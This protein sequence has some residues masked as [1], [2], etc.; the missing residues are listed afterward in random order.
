MKILIV[1]NEIYL[2]QS[3]SAKLTEIGY[4]CESVTTINEALKGGKYDAILLSTNISGQNFYPIIKKYKGAII[5]LLISYISQDTVLKPIKEGASDY[6]QKPFMIEELIR[7]L[8]HLRFFH[9]LKKQNQTYKNYIQYLFKDLKADYND[10]KIK[11]PLAIKT[12]KRE[13]ADYFVYQY[14]IKTNQ[15]F[16]FLSLACK[17]SLEKIIEKDEKDFLYLVDFQILKTQDKAKLLN[18]LKKQKVII[19]TTNKEDIFPFETLELF[20]NEQNSEHKNIQSIEDYVKS[21]IKTYQN[22]FSD[23]ELSKRLGISRKSLWEK[24]RKYDITKK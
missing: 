9:S 4:T 17:D 10:K 13:N 12:D 8:E 5:L 20:D 18:L 15:I 16:E 7:K 11:L 1:E 23:T 19:C 6:I 22:S 2:A 21:I 24:R 14:A 3:I